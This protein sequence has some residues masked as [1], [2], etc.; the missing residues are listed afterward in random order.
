MVRQV[1]IGITRIT[2]HYVECDK[3]NGLG[4]ITNPKNWAEVKT[5]PKCK[6]HGT[7]RG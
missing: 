3:C 2:T 7:V 5:C 6:G 1:H 4:T